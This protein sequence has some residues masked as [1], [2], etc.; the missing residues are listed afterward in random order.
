MAQLWQDFPQ[1]RLSI[2]RLGGVFNQRV[3]PGAGSRVALPE[4]RS[5]IRFEGVKFRYGLNEPWTLED[6]DIHLPAG[7]TQEIAGS[8]GSGKSTPTKLLQQP[9]IPS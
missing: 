2:D 8:S 6:I 1:V 4:I 9:Y 3:E 7:G 5:T